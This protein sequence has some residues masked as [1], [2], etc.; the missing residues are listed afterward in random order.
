[1]KRLVIVAVFPCILSIAAAE[2]VLGQRCARIEGERMERF[3]ESTAGREGLRDSVEA[4]T[5]AAGIDGGIV[6]YDVA[7][8][9]PTLTLV[10]LDVPVRS[11]DRI[12][13][14]LLEWARLHPE[15]RAM[16]LDLG[17]PEVPRRSDHVEQYRP[18]VK[19]DRATGDRLARLVRDRGETRVR[20]LREAI[21]DMY[22]DHQGRVRIVHLVQTTG[23]DSM[24]RA[25]RDVVLLMEWE[26]ARINGTPVG[27]W[28]RQPLR[29]GG[30]S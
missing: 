29:L 26:P 3:Q 9:P 4:L 20:S 24:D 12:H 8:L 28:V 10:D 17:A 22:V 6:H 1:M 25:I 16:T 2:P 30:G 14:L 19:N 23:D 13:A 27:A 15:D 11:K 5:G 7:S 18:R 21:L